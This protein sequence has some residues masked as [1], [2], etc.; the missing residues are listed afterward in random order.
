[1]SQ[2][3]LL[4]LLIAMMASTYSLMMIREQRKR[5][6]DKY[7]LVREAAYVCFSGASRVGETGREYM[8]RRIHV[9]HM[10]RKIHVSR[11]WKGSG[12]VYNELSQA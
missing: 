7:E 4:N 12:T 11:Q 6:L 9:C 1:M 5:L 2:Q 8:K 3:V 10:R